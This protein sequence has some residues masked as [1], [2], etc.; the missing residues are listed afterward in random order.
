MKAMVLHG[1]GQ[2]LV[3]EERADPIPGRGEVRLAVEACAVCR[4]D[5]HI[6]DGDLPNPKLPI[7]PGHEIVGRID[8]LGPHVDGFRIGQ[9]VAVAIG[10]KRRSAVE[11]SRG[12]LGGMR[13]GGEERGSHQRRGTNIARGAHRRRF[14]L[15]PLGFRPPRTPPTVPVTPVTRPVT[16]STAPPPV[17]PP[18]APFVT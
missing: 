9:R 13:R 5:L 3:L 10:G 11:R 17:V 8:A 16:G 15:P 4:T 1:P 2:A 6:V 7:V 12:G 18:V 14:Q